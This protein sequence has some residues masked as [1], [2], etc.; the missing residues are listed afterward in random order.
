[1]RG[2]FI[3]SASHELKTPVAIIQG[4]AAGLK[5]IDAEEKKNEYIDVIFKESER[6]DQI[7]QNLLNLSELENNQVQ[8]NMKKFDLATLTDEMMYTFNQIFNEKKVKVLINNLVNAPVEADQERIEHLL[9]NYISNALH[10]VKGDMKIQVDLIELEST[11]QFRIFNTGD[12]I[13]ENKLNEIWGAFY[14]VDRA[15]SREYGGT[16][17]GLAIVKR[18]CERHKFEY[19]AENQNDGVA[20]WVNIDKDYH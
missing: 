20:F 5:E 16:G 9:R 14:K 18:I 15:R 6:M 12:S 4:Y 7:I 8:L 1:M 19:G 10:H 3:S 13:P 2:E 17:L 11:F